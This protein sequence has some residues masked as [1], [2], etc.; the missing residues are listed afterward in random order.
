MKLKS[1]KR[2]NNHKNLLFLF[3]FVTLILTAL[4]ISWILRRPVPAISNPSYSNI[5]NYRH[6]LIPYVSGKNYIPNISATSYIVVDVNTNTVLTSKLPH[7][8][9]YP[10]SVTKLATALT[11]LNVYPLDDVI[12]IKDSYKEGKIMD[13]QAGEKIT[14]KSLVTAILVFSA[15]DAAYNLASHYPEGG[16]VGFIS[17][18]NSLAKSY[19]L[20]DTNFVNFD[21]IHND[22]HFS[23]VYD[24]AQL[25]R[26]A[27][28]NPIVGQYVKTK[29]ATVSDITGTIKHALITTNELLGIIPEVEGLKT[30]WTPEA[31]GCFVSL[32]SLD[33]HKLITVV[34]QSDD[35][36]ADTIRLINWSKENVIWREYQP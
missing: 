29:E 21:G 25:G 22:N 30:G 7:L 3:G 9:I 2:K 10:A 36:F 26:L 6:P 34:A 16:V 31:G 8:K 17:Q 14:I 24:L 18:M 13:L 11:A 12:T 32:V 1:K 23:S 5:L 19:S 27:I 35:R 20:D 33:G 15:N 4:L 28:K